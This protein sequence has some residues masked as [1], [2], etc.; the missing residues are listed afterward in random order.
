MNMRGVVNIETDCKLR[1][2][3]EH[4][5]KFAELFKKNLAWP[6]AV[7]IEKDKL[8]ISQDVEGNPA[9]GAAEEH[10]QQV[11]NRF[12]AALGLAEMIIG[13]MEADDKPGPSAAHLPKDPERPIAASKLR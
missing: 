6:G 10:G 9:A 13:I 11:M 4:V 5:E 7:K 12:E 2:G 1:I 8:T 3:P